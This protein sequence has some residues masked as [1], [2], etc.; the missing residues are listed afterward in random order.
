MPKRNPAAQFLLDVCA[1][2]RWKKAHGAITQELTSHIDDQTAAY[3]AEGMPPEEAEQQAVRQMGDPVALGKQ[4]DAVYRPQPAH[5][6]MI[7]IVLML[8]G[9]VFLQTCVLPGRL[10]VSQAIVMVCGL[11]IA[12]AAYFIDFRRL[13]ARWTLP[14]YLLCLLLCGWLSPEINGASIPLSYLLLLAPLPLCGCVNRCRHL[15]WRGLFLSLAAALLPLGIALFLHAS[16]AALAIAGIS[17]FLLLA[18]AAGTGW[19]ALPRRLALPAVLLPILLMGV[20][21]VVSF[22]HRLLPVLFPA[23]DPQGAGFFP[24]T[25]RSMLSDAVLIGPGAAFADI[26]N[27]IPVFHDSFMLTWLI[28]RYGWIVVVPVCALFLWLIGRGAVFAYHQ[29]SFFG[30]LLCTAAISVF[31]LQFLAYLCANC[32]LLISTYFPLPLLYGGNYS[33]L[34]NLLLMGVLLSA[35]R[36]GGLY[37]DAHMPQPLFDYADGTLHVHLK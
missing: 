37:T 26:P 14:A 28:A 13:F 32:G 6:L 22:S 31:S 29:N 25:I 36:H 8:L 9:G 18:L 12:A 7:C 5:S 19:F 34:V 10:R 11:A 16:P 4:F 1:G 24:L 27:K 2:V 30:K 3:L 23:Q 15:K 20:C 33:T 35:I 17:C 21:C